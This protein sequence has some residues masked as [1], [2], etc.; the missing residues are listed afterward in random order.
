MSEFTPGPWIITGQPRQARI[1]GPNGE[2][3]GA[4]RAKYRDAASYATRDANAR[5]IAAAPDIY[6]A[7]SSIATAD[8]SKWEADVRDQFREWAQNVARAALSKA[9]HD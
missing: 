5:L 1:I 2:A 3:V 6:A 8:P 4:C 7:L 9:S